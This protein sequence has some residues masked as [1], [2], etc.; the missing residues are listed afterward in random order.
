MKKWL[1]FFALFV[2]AMMLVLVNYQSF[3]SWD[4]PIE[5]IVSSKDISLNEFIQ[6]YNDWRFDK[7]IEKDLSILE[8]YEKTSKTGSVS[9]LSF[10]KNAE[11][12]YYNKYTTQ[13]SIQSSLSDLWISYT[14]S[15]SIETVYTNQGFISFFMEH[16]LPILLILWALILVFKFFWPKWWG[17]PFSVKAWK[18]NTKKDINTKFSDI[19]WMWEVKDEL[20]EIIDFLK[21]PKKYQDVGAR[22]PKWILL[23]WVPWSWKTLLA[24]AVAWEAKASFF[25]ASWSEFMEMLVWM[26]A[27]K[28]RELFAKAKAASPSIIFIDEI[29]AIGKRRGWGYSG[30]HQEQEQTLNQILTEMDWFE[31]DTS[32]IV[33]AAT[34]RPDTLDPAL[35]RSWRF[36][37]KIMVWTPTL[38]ERV[39]I[40]EYYLKNK[41]IVPDLDLKS[42]A[43]RMSG[44][45][46][47]D[48]ENIVNE[49]ALKIAKDWRKVITQD[50]F[51]YAFEKVLMW[52]EKKIK[53][54]NEKERKIVAYH[55]LWHAITAY[56]LPESDPVEKISIVSRWQALWVT[57]TLPQEDTYLYS[58]AKFLDELV[59]LLW[60]RAAEELF[61][62]KEAITTWA[63]N[64]FMKS[65]A[66]ARDMIL[67]YGMDEE[68]WQ[69]LYLNQ[70]QDDYNWH[71][72][73]Y[74][75][76]TAELA[77]QKIKDLI[78]TAYIKA[79]K[80]LENNSDLIHVMAEIL[81]EKE[82][83]NRTEFEEMM[84]DI[85]KAQEH[86]ERLR[87][88]RK[89]QEKKNQKEETEKEKTEKEKTTSTKK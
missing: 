47:A 20:I 48:L 46:W 44:F 70:D 13:K 57:W 36:D 61:F 81:L 23:H 58:K 41:K 18:L 29:D 64:D 7:I 67:K 15:V 40:L 39:L 22:P 4:G 71:F 26:W 1:W 88:E 74:S 85:T 34:N 76:T 31:T 87:R 80:I 19:A 66:I 17:F 79:K 35:L 2:V 52:P 38:D 45:V 72:R 54:M 42:L 12:I 82:Y 68:M 21:N 5:Q 30:W 53:T 55:E 8:W 75:D 73:R 32:V 56:T 9:L 3:F 51:E 43:K 28:V 24:K 62:W 89:E 27:A 65:T 6:E 37:R 60:W 63:S 84:P 49:A 59:K 69:I 86:L 16:I 10:R 77:D 78:K 33:I 25:S 14:W 83:I 11:I 50:D